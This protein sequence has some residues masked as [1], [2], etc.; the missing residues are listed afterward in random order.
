MEYKDLLKIFRQQSYPIDHQSRKKNINI[1]V[2][3]YIY[4]AHFLFFSFVH[5][6]YLMMCVFVF[7]TN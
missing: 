2:V 4:N 5:N 7:M 6:I 1:A 3:V